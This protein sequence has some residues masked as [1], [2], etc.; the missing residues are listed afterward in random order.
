MNKIHNR[1]LRRYA[2]ALIM[3]VAAGFVTVF[4]KDSIDARN[5]EISL[6]IINVTTGYTSI[7][8]SPRAGYEWNFG[9]KTVRSPFVSSIDVPLVAYEALPDVPILIG[10]TTPHTNLTLYESPG[11]MYDGRVM[12]ADDSFVERRFGM[13]TPT[14]EGIYVYKVVAQFERGTIVHYFA[15]DVAASNTIY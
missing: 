10:F 5:P 7:P 8:N 9:S 4:I 12:A 1:A 3:L 2:I 13:N 14:K 11:V 15:L 6:P